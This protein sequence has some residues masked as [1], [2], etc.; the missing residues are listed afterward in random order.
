MDLGPT[1]RKFILVF[2]MR[3]FDGARASKELFLSVRPVDY[4]YNI[5]E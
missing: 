1:L 5:F 4:K 3:I 2:K